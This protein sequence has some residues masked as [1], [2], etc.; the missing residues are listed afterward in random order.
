MSPLPKSVDI[1][2]DQ[3]VQE[4]PE[5]YEAMAYEFRAFA[6]SR[7]IKS[8]LQ[9]LQVV[10]LYCGVDLSL[11]GAAGIVTL[12]EER[13]TDT[14]IHKRLK[15]C[16]PWLKAMC[17]HL[18]EERTEGLNEGHLRFLI[19]DGSTVQVP[20]AEGIS[21]RL[22]LAIDLLELE[23][24]T[25]KISDAHT[26]ESLDHFPL[27]GGDVVVVDRGYNQPL[28]L[29]QASERGVSVVL[30]YNPHGMNVYD[31]SM[32][33]VDVYDWLK[34]QKTH[35]HR[36]VR[37]IDAKKGHY[38]EMTL[39]ALPL[40]EAEADKARQRLRRTA[41]KRLHTVE[42]RPVPGRLGSGA[43]PSAS[44]AARYRNHWPIVPGALA[45]GTVYQAF[46][47]LV[48]LGPVAGQG[49]KRTGR[50]VS[51]RQAALH[52]GPGKAGQKTFWP[53]MD[54]SGPKAPGNLV[55]RVAT[56]QTRDRY[57]D[58]DALAMAERTPRTMSES[59]DGTTSKA[60]LAYSSKA[61]DRFGGALQ[62]AGI[63]QCMN[64]QL[65]MA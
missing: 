10:M 19:V 65:V 15:A 50:S 4:L 58:S 39:H 17:Q 26:G 55:A 23:M 33:K 56:S 64:N 53:A 9:L 7:K 18:H 62:R 25:V 11:R 29:I 2:F 32:R 8:P 38:V 46:E 5:D 59:H 21:Y 47:K 22:H 44:H 24:V 34:G 40:P 48:G 37:V 45:G 35:R 42:N 16:G 12:L 43:D 20:G 41:K 57:S 30:R 28:S 3:F 36:T 63:E 54:L 13:M 14:A 6:R 31:E 49:R 51:V 1:A 61:S 52:P 27:Q 60:Y